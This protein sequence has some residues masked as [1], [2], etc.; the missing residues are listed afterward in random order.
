MWFQSDTNRAVKAQK[1]ARDGKLELERRG[2][3]YLHFKEYSELVSSFIFISMNILSHCFILYL[4]FIEY[5]ES[6]FPYLFTFQGIFRVNIS[7]FIYISRNILSHCFLIYLHF[8][9]YFESLFHCLFTFQG[10][11]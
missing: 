6:L 3:V 4:H 11:F 7:L 9:E 2:I 8:I 5:F 1:M 10:I